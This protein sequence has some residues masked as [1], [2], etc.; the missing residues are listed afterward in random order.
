[1]LQGQMGGF[2][3]GD[4]PA[5]LLHGRFFFTFMLL[6]SG[7]SQKFPIGSLKHKF[8][9]TCLFPSF[10]LE[11]RQKQ[12]PCGDPAGCPPPLCPMS[13]NIFLIRSTV[14]LSGP[15]CIVLRRF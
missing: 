2:P 5:S 8:E 15:V 9:G 10:N 13:G 7:L 3:M 12:L 6:L 4:V 11:P 1:M 14:S